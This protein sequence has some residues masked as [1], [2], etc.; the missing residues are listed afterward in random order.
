MTKKRILLTGGGSGGHV[1]P[2]VA[3]AEELKRL[4]GDRIKIFYIGPR[5]KLNEEFENREI[6]VYRIAGAKWRRYF[7]PRNL[8]DIPKFFISFFQALFRIYFI[9]PD[10]VFSKG[11]TG[12][13]PV[14]LAARFYFIPVMIHD[15]DSVPGLV[16]KISSR[17]AKKIFISFKT[18]ASYFPKKEVELVGNPIRT[19]II[20]NRPPN[21]E[22]AKTRIRLKPEEPLVVFLGGSQGAAAI[23]DFVFNN[24]EKLVSFAQIFHQVGTTS[25]N[26]AER[27]QNLNERYRYGGFIDAEQM[28]AV[29]AAA[30]VVVSRAGSAAIFEIASF[31]KPAILIPL[32]EGAGNHQKINAYEYERSGAAIVIEQSNLSLGIIKLEIEKILNNPAVREN[33]SQAARGFS[34]PEAAEVIAKRILEFT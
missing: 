23:N 3:V 20:V 8:I 5:E 14:V 4:A 11:G 28:K 34:K 32:P 33:M 21:T 6:K 13:L 18:A 25:L 30:D 7:D 9:M 19:E 17:F 29:L 1:V 2:L 12:A 26:E 15:S 16:S 27:L 31:G 22:V 24:F 10:V